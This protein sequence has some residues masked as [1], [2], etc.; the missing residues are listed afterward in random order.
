MV[1]YTSG[2]AMLHS[3]YITS[4]IF[5]PK[6]QCSTLF[7]SNSAMVICVHTRTHSMAHASNF[8]QIDVMDRIER[9]T[10]ASPVLD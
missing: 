4:G 1:A 3:L 5:L 6:Q 2:Q 9:Y 8:A 10:G 7:P